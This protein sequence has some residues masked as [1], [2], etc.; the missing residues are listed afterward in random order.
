MFADRETS[1]V[2]VTFRYTGRRVRWCRG[3]GTGSTLR[4]RGRMKVRASCER[5]VSRRPTL[6]AVHW[7]WLGCV[8][9]VM[10]AQGWGYAGV[11]D[12]RMLETPAQATLSEDDWSQLRSG[13]FVIHTQRATLN[14]GDI[15]GIVD[16]P[17]A[18]VWS[19]L[20]EF[21]HYAR[22]MRQLESTE[23]VRREGDVQIG[24]G[25]TR[26]PFPIRDR[27]WDVEVRGG[28]RAVA[29]ETHYVGTWSYI[30]GSGNVE[31]VFGFWYVSPLPGDPNRSLVRYV[32]LANLGIWIPNAI[33]AWATGRMLP[34]ILH[35]LRAEV[36]RRS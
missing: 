23:V 30:P 26:V 12:A 8:L 27:H 3:L 34:D 17:P 4:T 28:P 5:T 25:V 22:W 9:L 10:A 21:A 31:E 14:R 32:L 33:L 18:R 36:A 11:A 29:G 7:R 19:V 16:A 20:E 24:R 15:T 13:G 35:D 1:D 2:V 6:C